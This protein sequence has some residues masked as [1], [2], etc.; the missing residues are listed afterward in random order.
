MGILAGTITAIRRIVDLALIGLILVVLF[1][2]FLGKIVP[3]T[4]HQTII[5]GG[6]SM[7]PA[8]GLGSAIVIAPVKPADLVQGDVVSLRVGPDRATFTHRI[9]DVFDRPDGVWIRTKGDANAEPDPTLVPA[10][11]IIGRVEWSIPFAGYL[12]ALLSLPV[13][14]VFVLGLAATLLAIAW[15][16][17]SVEVDPRRETVGSA[18]DASHGEPIPARGNAPRAGILALPRIWAAM[19]APSA[20]ANPFRQVARPNV[21]EQ[22]AR[23]REVRARRHHWLT[24][25][26]RGPGNGT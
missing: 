1:G 14:V 24:T 13:G 4:G 10:T 5:I 6:G 21:P 15:L 18:P 2:L 11:A 22:L 12:M 7:Q 20:S 3:L 9:I 17:E 16:L 23:S 26:E 25:R 19:A 8:I